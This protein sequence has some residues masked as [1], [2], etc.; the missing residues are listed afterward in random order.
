MYAGNLSG[1]QSILVPRGGQA[2]GIRHTILTRR[3]GIRQ[4]TSAKGVGNLTYV[5]LRPDIRQAVGARG[6]GIKQL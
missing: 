2:G 3:A 1:Y 5:I 4:E 6:R